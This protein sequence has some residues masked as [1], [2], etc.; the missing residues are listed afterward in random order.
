MLLKVRLSAA[1]SQIDCSVHAAPAERV[2]KLQDWR[3]TLHWRAV[4][5]DDYRGIRAEDFVT[6]NLLVRA[7]TAVAVVRVAVPSVVVR[8]S[9]RVLCC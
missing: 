7:A 6:M 9:Y 2:R 3:C 5:C 8:P 1:E 4:C